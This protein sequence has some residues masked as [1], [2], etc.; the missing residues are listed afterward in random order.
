MAFSLCSSVISYCETYTGL[1][2][3]SGPGTPP[4]DLAGDT[5]RL[6]YLLLNPGQREA[7]LEGMVGDPAMFL[8]PPPPKSMMS[9]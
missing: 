4:T 8:T 6:N 9:Y 5:G 7:E 1:R 2:F 3:N